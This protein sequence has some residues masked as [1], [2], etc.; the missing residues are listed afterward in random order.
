MIEKFRKSINQEG[1]FTTLVTELLKAFEIMI[2]DLLLDY[3]CAYGFDS[4]SSMLK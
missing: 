4:H 1:E 3:Q 2:Q